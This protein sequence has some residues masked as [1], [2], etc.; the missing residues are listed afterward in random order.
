[1]AGYKYEEL[2][3]YTMTNHFIIRKYR[4]RDRKSVR[5]IACDTGFLGEPVECFFDGRDLFA[6]FMTVYYTDFEPESCFVAEKGGKVIGYLIGT[7]NRKKMAN[8]FIKNIF[9]K[10]FIKTLIG[11]MYFKRRNLK[12]FLFVLV[13]FL[14]GQFFTKIDLK[15]YPALFHINLKKDYRNKGQGR[16]LV[17]N[18]IEYLKHKNILGVHAA[19]HSG[20]AGKF[21][22]KNN[23]T[24][25]YEK[26]RSYFSHVTGR[27]MEYRCY[28][29][30][31]EIK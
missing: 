5:K 7:K 27:D 13:S 28:G 16:I 6:D 4:N 2:R 25:L 19:T 8:T 20:G 1:M 21:F 18:Y 3:L 29:K 24:V 30:V 31:L 11:G 12:F 23:F 17:N 9:P 10:L 14:K 26:K 15:K 22:K